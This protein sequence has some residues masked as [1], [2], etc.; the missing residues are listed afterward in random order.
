MTQHFL[1]ELNE[2]INLEPLRQVETSAFLISSLLFVLLL[3]VLVFDNL[4]QTFAV[5]DLSKLSL[6]I[7][8]D[9]SI[10]ID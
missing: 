3:K 9:K 1:V 2:I 4:Y 5:L 6:P 8:W 10:G 7:H